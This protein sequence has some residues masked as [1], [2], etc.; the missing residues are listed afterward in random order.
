MSTSPAPVIALGVT[1]SI[2]A[3]KA[4]DLVSR[5]TKAGALVEVI[6]T[7]DAQ[8]FITPL[9]LKTLS[10]RP[11]ITSL[12]DEDEEWKPS[13]IR[14]ADEASLMVIAPATANTIARLALGLAD[15]ALTSTALALNPKAKFLIAPAMNGKMW[16]HPATQGHVRTLKERGVEFIGPEEGMLSC[17]YEG[18]GRLWPVED[19]ARRC[20][21]L[22]GGG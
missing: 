5:L 12:Y 2:A 19:I 6:L 1:G 16:L 10:R 22:L 18:L 3:Y 9:T 7:A 4:A 15:D 8:Q 13:H 20:L 14:V 21:E 17:G 11:V